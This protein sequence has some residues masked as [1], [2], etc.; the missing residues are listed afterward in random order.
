MS[1]SHGVLLHEFFAHNIGLHLYIAR[2]LLSGRY[3]RT[4]FNAEVGKRSGQSTAWNIISHVPGKVFF[5]V[6]NKLDEWKNLAVSRNLR[7]TVYLSGRMWHKAGAS[8]R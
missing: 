6:R 3:Q 5:H 8:G 1:I 4:D 2:D 7:E